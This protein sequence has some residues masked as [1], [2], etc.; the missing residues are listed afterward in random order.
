MGKSKLQKEIYNVLLVMK[1]ERKMRP[2]ICGDRVEK[3]RRKKPGYLLSRGRKEVDES[4]KLGR[5]GG[6]LSQQNFLYWPEFGRYH[7]G[8]KERS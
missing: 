3:A 4:K 1:K 5:V 8:R 7:G 6:S 2:G